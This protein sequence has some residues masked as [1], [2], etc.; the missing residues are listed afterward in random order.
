VSRDSVGD[1]ALA[2][3]V[4]LGRHLAEHCGDMQT[5]HGGTDDGGDVVVTKRD[6]GHQEAEHIEGCFIALLHLLLHVELE[7]VHRNVARTFDHHLQVVL[8]SAANQLTQS[9]QLSEP[10]ATAAS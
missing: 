9:V 8:P 6:V 1:Q 7:L 3:I 10:R 2:H 5:G 4:A